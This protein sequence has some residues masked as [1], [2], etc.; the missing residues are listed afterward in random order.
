M[1]LDEGAD[2][3]RVV[4]CGATDGGAVPLGDHP[5]VLVTRST[6]ELVM[7]GARADLAVIVV[8]ALDGITA[9]TQRD[10]AIVGLIGI[11]PVVLAVDGCNGNE[12][13][14]REI[15]R[16]I[17]GL[18]K[19]LG[20][21]HVTAVPLAAA[22][23]DKIAWH[24]GPTLDDCLAHAGR[25]RAAGPAF[26]FQVSGVG[27]GAA[28]TGIMQSGTVGAGDRVRIWPARAEAGIARIDA[29]DGDAVSLLLDGEVAVAVGDVI[30]AAEDSSLAVADQ[31]QATLI[32]L[33]DAPLVPGRRLL[34][35]LGTAESGA[36]VSTLKH[37]L[38]F[39][40]GAL[41]NARSLARDQIGVVTLTL[42]RALAFDSHAANRDTSGF[43][44]LDPESGAEIAFGIIQYALRR[45]TNVR[46]HEGAID[47]SVRARLKGQK[48]VCLWFTGLSG[49]GKSTLA[50]RVDKRL[51][52]EGRHTYVLDGD[53]VR[54][55]LNH[56]LGF[57]E[58]DRVENIRR[59]AEVAKLMVDAG[60]IVMVCAISPYRR[61]RDMA[62]GLFENGEFIEVFVD[63]AL[64]ACEA[65]D[66]KGLYQKARAGEIPNFTG[67]SAPYEAPESPEIR[68]DGTQP[69]DGLVAQV[70]ERLG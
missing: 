4:V 31:L 20:I 55:G 27:P 63:T 10:T 48:P 12:A 16:D 15:E 25:D 22:R 8:D 24:D 45:A 30:A 59:M 1:T 7:S 26:C 41:V 3:L 44:L 61:D 47:K 65:R 62:R 32:W 23:G 28:C 2:P 39:T 42:D 38:D 50:N 68:L 53:N 49:A 14:F 35:R 64:A 56:D 70:F 17:A 52:A 6:R 13:R 9:R 36:A 69:L 33:A 29:A 54:H 37:R 60:L 18:A 21:D 58:T 40:S 34:A 51:V 46:W 66:P 57:T 43:A 19:R 11:G 67:I 5:A